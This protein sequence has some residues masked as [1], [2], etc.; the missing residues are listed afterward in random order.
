MKELGIS[1]IKHV[2]QKGTGL[3]FVSYPDAIAKFNMVPQFFSV[4]FFLM[5]YTLGIGTAVALAA[6]VISVICDKFTKVEHGTASLVLCIVG[7]L[8][9][10]IYVTPV[11]E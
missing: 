1:D 3:V 6:A 2:V 4:V 9:G 11:S 10:L 7:F 8:V 5:L